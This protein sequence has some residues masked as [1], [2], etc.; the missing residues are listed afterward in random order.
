MPEPEK[1]AYVPFRQFRDQIGSTPPATLQAALL[2]GGSAMVAAPNDAV[3]WAQRQAAA[4]ID[5]VQKTYDRTDVANS[6]V[7]AH[8]IHFDCVKMETQPTVGAMAGLDLSSQPPPFVEMPGAPSRRA[9]VSAQL[10]EDRKDQF[11]NRVYCPKGYVPVMRVTPSMIAQAGGMEIFYQKSPDGGRHPTFGSATNT[12][13]SI[14]PGGGGPLLPVQPDAQGAIHAY[15]HA[16]QGLTS[17][18]GAFG[19]QS[20]LNVWNPNP[21]P[22]VFTL[23]QQWFAGGSGRGLQTVEGGWHVYPALYQGSPLARLFI[24]FTADGYASTGSYNLTR[25][26]GQ[27]GFIQTDNTWV[28]G[29]SFQASDAGG[30][31][32]GF[33]MQWRRSDQGDWWLYLQGSGDPAAVGYYPRQLFGNGAMAQA[34]GSVDFGGEVCSQAGGRQTG[35]MGSGQF[36]STGWQ[37]A[38]FH[39]SIGYITSGGTLTPA[40][41]TNIQRDAPFYTIDPHSGGGGSW[42][43]YFF[44]GG[45]NGQ[46]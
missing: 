39:R 41:P 37:Q 11:D 34:A 23:S 38:A 5:H 35:P 17:Q 9:G 40:T 32:R 26:P 46:F 45:P 12:P 43:T 19:G 18:G 21:S 1:T 10:S 22:G 31:Q 15:A 44:F 2:G 33:L 20:W 30:E 8:G 13:S 3:D 27:G 6:F 36:A 24:F 14:V 25:R 42:S 29:G 28:I 7:D 16:A 4:I